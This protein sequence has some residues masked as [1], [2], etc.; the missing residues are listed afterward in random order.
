M[1]ILAALEKKET[2]KWLRIIIRLIDIMLNAVKVYGKYIVKIEDNL[3]FDL[4]AKYAQGLWG[5]AIFM[6]LYWLFENAKN[7]VILKVSDRYSYY[8]YL[9]HQ[10]FILGPLSLMKLTSNIVINMVIICCILIVG[11]LLEKEAVLINAVIVINN[12]SKNIKAVLT[13]KVKR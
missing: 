10:I 3:I 12:V 1:W 11:I 8:V 13:K 5:I 4:F 2:L 6:L 7:N 9:V